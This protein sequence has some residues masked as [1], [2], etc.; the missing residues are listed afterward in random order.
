M[1][2]V[3]KLRRKAGASYAVLPGKPKTVAC[4]P[5]S[6]DVRYVK[7][8]E[9]LLL[10]VS[11]VAKI[12]NHSDSHIYAMVYRRELPSVRLR[13]IARQNRKAIRIPRKQLLAWIEEQIIPGYGSGANR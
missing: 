13:G 5:S 3:T 12:L 6:D 10:K 2:K 9:P 1:T 7:T 11:D 8:I 4:L